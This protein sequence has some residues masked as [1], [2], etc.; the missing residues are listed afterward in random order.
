M[1]TPEQLIESTIVAA[2]RRNP[3]IC[4]RDLVHAITEALIEH[5]LTVHSGLRV[6]CYRGLEWTPPAHTDGKRNCC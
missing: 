6:V 4:P 1:I 5:S 3:D 2:Q